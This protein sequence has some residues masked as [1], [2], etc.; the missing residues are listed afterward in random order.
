MIAAASKFEVLNAQVSDLYLLSC[1][2]D[3]LSTNLL[4]PADSLTRLRAQRRQLEALQIVFQWL[5]TRGWI[6]CNTCAAPVEL[7]TRRFSM[8]MVKMVFDCIYEQSVSAAYTSKASR[9]S[10]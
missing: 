10:S 8:H 1:S 2:G 9:L 5:V 3:S 7:D 4:F 6:I